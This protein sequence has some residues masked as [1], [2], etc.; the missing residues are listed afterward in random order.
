MWGGRGNRVCK[1]PEA[2]AGFAKFERGLLS[3][4]L[5]SACFV[6]KC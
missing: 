4:R 5:E 3:L 2:G 1:G 6:G